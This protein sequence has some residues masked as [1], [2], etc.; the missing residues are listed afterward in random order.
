MFIYLRI[1]ISFAE[2][3]VN[4]YRVHVRS[5][6][7]SRAGVCY[8]VSG[9]SASPGLAQI[10]LPRLKFRPHAIGL[11]SA[12]TPHTTIT[13]ACPSLFYDHSNDSRSVLVGERHP[14]CIFMN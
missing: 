14:F 6:E 3:A 9:V 2:R 12:M 4:R 7:C 1:S 10:V 8:R 13:N 5:V 11:C